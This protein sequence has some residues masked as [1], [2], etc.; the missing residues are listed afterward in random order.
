MLCMLFVLVFANRVPR[1]SVV[2]IILDFVIIFV[3]FGFM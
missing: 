2:F 3:N 1:F